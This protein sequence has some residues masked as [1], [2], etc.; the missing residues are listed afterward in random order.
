LLGCTSHKSTEISSY[1]NNLRETCQQKIDK[2]CCLASVDEME[3]RHAKV[4]PKE[5]CREGYRRE[6]FKCRSS[7]SWCEVEK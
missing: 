5:G 7:F 4:A 3:K 1:Y 2:N 6:M